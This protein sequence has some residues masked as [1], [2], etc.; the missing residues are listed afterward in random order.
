[1][2]KK[3]AKCTK[4]VYPTEE[5]KCLDKIWHK[6]CF[7]CE[8]CGMTLNMKNYKGYDKLPY[9]NAH[10]PQTKHTAVADTPE[11]RRIAENTKI[12]SNVSIVM[13]PVWHLW[14]TC[15]DVC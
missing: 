12:Q 15:N 4:T 11:A 8:V 13:F 10:Y 14:L 7:K 2:S 9:C 5:L 1:M 6:A 3:C